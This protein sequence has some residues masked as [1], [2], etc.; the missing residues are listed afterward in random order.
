VKAALIGA[1]TVFLFDKQGQLLARSDK[2]VEE[3]DPLVGQPFG[4][5]KWVKDPIDTW[6]DAS[7]TIRE[8]DVLAAVAS[9]SVVAGEKA[10]N[11]ARLEGVV[12]A[13]FGYD[14]APTRS[15]HHGR[16]GGLRDQHRE[17]DQPPALAVT[18]ETAGFGAPRFAGVSAAPGA[19][20]TPSRK[21]KRSGPST[22]RSRATFAS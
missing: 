5:V 10:M 2:T 20:D 4:S 3:L 13:S 7:G 16:A 17:K 9:A 14:K 6:A 21:A 8:K 15:G 22:G 1:N 18:T 19:L 12:A 11:E